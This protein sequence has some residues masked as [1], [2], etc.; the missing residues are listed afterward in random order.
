MPS[1]MSLNLP[2]PTP[3]LQY[4]PAELVDEI[5]QYMSP[6]SKLSL[7]Y[8]CHRFRHYFPITIQSMQKQ[9]PT[10]SNSYSE[11]RNQW[12]NFLC[13]LER[14]KRISQLVCSACCQTHHISLF[15]EFSKGFSQRTGL[16]SCLA[17]R[18][19]PW[20]CP[21]SSYTRAELRI[22]RLYAQSHTRWRPF[23]VDIA[24]GV[25]DYYIWRASDHKDKS[26]FPSQYDCS[27]RRIKRSQHMLFLHI[28]ASK[29]R[30]LQARLEKA[31]GM[32]AVVK[33]SHVRNPTGKNIRCIEH[34][35]CSEF[36]GGDPSLRC[37]LCIENRA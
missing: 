11:E 28:E 32:S 4:L 15:S 20:I 22:L 30:S 14:D 1:T 24:G 18:G 21:H 12:Y 29:F 26:L 16:R 35:D 8:T 36:H 27:C 31:L 9:V 23:L 6:L 2:P 3:N 7:R 17:S 25:K 37:R 13:M 34:E 5:A 10:K 33:C 19:Q